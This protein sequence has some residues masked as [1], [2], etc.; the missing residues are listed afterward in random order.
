MRW[1]WTASYD[2]AQ[3]LRPLLEHALHAVVYRG[4]TRVAQLLHVPYRKAARIIERQ[5][6]LPWG[7]VDRLEH[8]GIPRG[9]GKA[10]AIHAAIE[11]VEKRA[12]FMATRKGL[13]RVRN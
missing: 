2:E 5:A 13:K 8:G 3:P 10:Y 6:G 4:V 11:V 9:G 1:T 12:V 7:A